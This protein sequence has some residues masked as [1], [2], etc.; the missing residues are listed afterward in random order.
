MMVDIRHFDIFNRRY[1][2]ENGDNLL[3]EI[4]QLVLMNIKDEDL[5]CRYASD[6]FIILLPKTSKVAAEKIAEH[7][8]QSIEHL[9]FKVGNLPDAVYNQVLCCVN[10]YHSDINHEEILTQLNKKMFDTKTA[11]YRYIS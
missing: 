3:R 11:L 10:E 9:A 1:G 5:A 6:R 8:E 2:D 4:A 7:I